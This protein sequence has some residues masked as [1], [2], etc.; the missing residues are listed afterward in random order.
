MTLKPTQCALWLRPAVP[1]KRRNFV[2][3]TFNLQN[4]ALRRDRPNGEHKSSQ[5][6]T[7]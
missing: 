6:A 1:P 4:W 3:R 7:A 5:G 2:F